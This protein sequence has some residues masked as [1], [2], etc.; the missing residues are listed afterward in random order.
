MHQRFFSLT[1][2]RGGQ[3]ATNSDRLGHRCV[4]VHLLTSCY[5]NLKSSRVDG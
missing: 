2:E 1:H 3:T 4:N 5:A